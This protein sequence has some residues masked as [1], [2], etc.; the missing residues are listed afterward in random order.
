MVVHLTPPRACSRS[1]VN[2]VFTLLWCNCRIWPIEH[3][4]GK[5]IKISFLKWLP[6]CIAGKVAWHPDSV[7]Y[8][9]CGQPTNAR[10]H[11]FFAASYLFLVEHPRRTFTIAPV[12]VKVASQTGS[13]SKHPWSTALSSQTFNASSSLFPNAS[14]EG[15]LNTEERIT[16]KVLKSIH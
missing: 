10:R 15:H 6:F 1:V 16:T 11:L 12:L 9:I 5:L 8:A 2:P 7:Q 13:C 14:H 4:Q 3:I